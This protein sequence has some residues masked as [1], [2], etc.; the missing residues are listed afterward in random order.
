M[1]DG[2]HTV[3]SPRGGRLGRGQNPNQPIIPDLDDS[4]PINGHLAKLIRDNTDDGTEAA[5]LLIRIA[6]NDRNSGD[7]TA[8]HRVTAARE[9]IH[10]AYD[11][12][13][14]AVTWEHVVAY[15]QATDFA[16]EGETLEYARIEAD[17]HALIREYREASASGDEEATQAAEDRFNNYNRHIKEGKAPDTAMKYANYGPND[18]IPEELHT[19]NPT[20][21]VR[22]VTPARPE[23]VEG[24]VGTI[25]AT[26]HTPKL[27]V[28]INNRSP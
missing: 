26:I 22:P 13:Y 19:Q 27:T 1:E 17:R 20:H 28:P 3:P 23:P 4:D 14:E 8:A 5:E 10:R 7:W 21:P 15:K 2:S 11:L 9:L 25:A 18:P 12:N 16:D 6:E 24:H